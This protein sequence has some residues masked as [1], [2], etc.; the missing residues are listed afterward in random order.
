MRR[1]S[2]RYLLPALV[3]LTVVA[4]STDKDAFL[5]RTFHKLVTRD[6]GW[7]NANEKL[8]ETGAAMQKGHVDD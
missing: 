5:N 8:K 7:F 6:N 3:V 4:C 1:S 2:L